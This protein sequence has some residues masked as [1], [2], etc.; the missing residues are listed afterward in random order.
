MQVVEFSLTIKYA[1]EEL[2]VSCQRFQ[3]IK[4]PQIR[5]LVQQLDKMD[6]VFTFYEI[7]KINKDFFYFKPQKRYKHLAES[8]ENALI[9]YYSE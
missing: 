3:V 6:E 2:V 5:V 9:E 7:D 8:I 1:G 4:V